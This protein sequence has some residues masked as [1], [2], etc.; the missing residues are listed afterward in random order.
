MSKWFEDDEFWLEFRDILFHEERMKKTSY[1]VDRFIDI[2][3]L[4]KEHKILDFVCGVGRHTLEFASRGYD[5]TGVDLSSYYIEEAEQKARHKNID[6]EFIEADM[7]KFVRQ[8]TYDAVINFFTSFGY[9][10]DEADNM[11]VLKNVYSSLKPGGR[12]LLDVMGKEVLEKIYTEEDWIRIEEGYFVEKRRFKD[13]GKILESDWKLMKDD[14]E[15]K[16]HKFIYRVYSETEIKR[17][18]E[19]AGFRDLKTYGD[20]ELS[21]YDEE[22]SRLIILAKK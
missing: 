20:L 2:L 5:V 16:E 19:K 14:G 15:I 6:A 21:E 10:E 13:R 17:L 9:F 7:R 11:R 1:Q 3:D 4:D 18:M 22:A 8:D 12:F